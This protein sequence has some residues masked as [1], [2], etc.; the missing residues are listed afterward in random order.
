M[1]PIPDSLRKVIAADPFMWFCIH[2]GRTDVTWEHAIIINGKQ[3]IERWATVPCI[4]EFNNDAHGDDK[5]FSQL[6]AFWR[7]WT[8]CPEYI[9]AQF[10]KYPKFDFF[11]EFRK[12]LGIYI[13]TE[14]WQRIIDNRIKQ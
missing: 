5:H 3:C 9:K 10:E 6:I 13:P 14:L 1:R 7:L 2:T 11:G 4:R 8:A 12:L